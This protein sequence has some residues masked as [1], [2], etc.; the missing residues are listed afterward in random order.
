MKHPTS[1]KHP[2][3][4]MENR[5][6]QFAPFAAL[7]GYDAKIAET[8]RLTHREIQLTEDQKDAL[9]LRFQI[10]EDN[11]G[12]DVEFTLTYFVPDQHKSG[13]DYLTQSGTI[14]KIDFN[15][16][17]LTFNTGHEI[18][19]SSIV[20]INSKIFKSYGLDL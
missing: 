2:R 19:I 7:T 14:K 12:K 18:K 5:A 17:I 8:A 3:M 15:K 10:L 13:G 16:G 4:S 20:E 9:N 11:L 1:M 6:A